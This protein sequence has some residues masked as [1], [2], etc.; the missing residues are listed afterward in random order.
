MIT[1]GDA[2]RINAL[3][4]PDRPCLLDRTRRFTYAEVNERVNRLANGLLA[5]G[6]RPGQTVAVFSHNSI[7]YMELFHALAKL[8]C[9]M[10]T[11][12]VWH[13]AGEVEVL[14]KHS[15]AEWFI[16]GEKAQA[17]V[18]ELVDRLGL[19]PGH[20]IVMGEPELPGAVAW[21]DVMAAGHPA[22]PGVRVDPQAPYWMMYTSGTTGNPKGVV[23]SFLRTALCTW[24]GIIEFR[25]SKD[26][27]FLA[28]S[29]FFHGVT[30]LPIMV[31][32]VG[33][34]VFIADRFSVDDIIE[35]LGRHRITSGFMVPT[36]L[37]MLQADPR[38]GETDFSALRV[39][40]TGG[41][42]MPE[43]LKRRILDVIGPSLFEFYG[44]SESGFLTVLH[45]EDQLTRIGS[46]GRACFGAEVQIRGE[47]G[48]VLPP[49]Q[50]GEIFTS[51]QGRFDGYYK[52]PERT[53]QALQDGWFT[54]GDLGRMDE[55][56]YVYIV[57]RKSDLIISGGENVYPIE[58]EDVLRSHP[59]VADCAV[60]GV[61]DPLWGEAVK[62]VVVLRPGQA[63]AAE[64][65]V[66]Y[67]SRRLAGFKRPKYVEFVDELPRNASG[68]VLKHVLKQQHGA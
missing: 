23:R 21:N 6:V 1:L 43:A 4:Y 30:F 12:N 3:K 59:A 55:D 10:V 40:V 14:Y 57:G 2:L 26:D 33:G 29:P 25:F 24:A 66:N 52:D 54:A 8:G 28:V 62:A 64:E 9:C 34:A 20:L 60:I 31:L 41:A 50:V 48:E 63:V 17:S 53:A 35:T 7:E 32:H 15:D 36:M 49:G 58:I 45:P 46:C 16:V 61:P 27:L 51:C 56:G 42:P 19:A 38:F 39:L 44:A 47:S 5:T 37:N 13:R 11:L 67:C 65:L 68:K 22:E 18:A